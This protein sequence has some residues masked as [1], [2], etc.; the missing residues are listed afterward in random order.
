[1]LTTPLA[2][3]EQY[4]GTLIGGCL[5]NLYLILGQVHIRFIIL[6]TH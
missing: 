1:M 2:H 6:L 3:D 5:E 4:L